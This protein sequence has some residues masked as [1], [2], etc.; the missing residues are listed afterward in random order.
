MYSNIDEAWK[1]S[2]DLDKYKKEFKPSSRVIDATNEIKNLS[3]SEE[4]KQNEKADRSD[5][6]RGNKKEKKIHSPHYS[7]NVRMSS[8]NSALFRTEMTD[9][10][11]LVKKDD[12]MQCDRLFSHFQSCKKCRNK[13]V[14]KFS[15]NSAVAVDQPSLNLQS[16]KFT[17][18]FIDMSKYT[19]LLKN[20]N[21]N[22]IISIVLFGLLVIIILSMLN[23]ENK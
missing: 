6:N 10:K 4:K 17:E 5:R 19:D 23:N 13:I 21:Y 14:E 15:L 2:N 11:K 12:G 8:P 16:F 1:T 20:K 7:D 22:N 3:T 9:L 18:S